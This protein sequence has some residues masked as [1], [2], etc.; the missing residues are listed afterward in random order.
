[1][2]VRDVHFLLLVKL[3]RYKRAGNNNDYPAN[4][5]RAMRMLTLRDNSSLHF[6]LVD[7]SNVNIIF[8]RS[9]CYIKNIFRYIINEY[10]SS[11]Q[12]NQF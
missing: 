11:L 4:A 3:S 9:G 1:M 10:F 5:M 6:L 12:F 7:F 8:N 2:K